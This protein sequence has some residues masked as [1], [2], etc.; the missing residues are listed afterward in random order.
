MKKLN[1]TFFGTP[2]FSVKILEKLKKEGFMPS[3]VVTTPDKP[4]GRK[5]VLT[6]PPTKIWAKENGINV[7][8]P[9]K[10]KDEEFLNKL[11]ETEWD[12]FI[13]ASYGKIIP[14]AVL[15]I[16]KH[17]TINVHPSLLPRL[18]GASPMQS[19]ILTEDK[20]GMTIMLM[21]AGM[22]HGPIL[23]QKELD[24]PN[25]PPKISE[26]ENMLAEI[27]GEML[28]ETIPLW[29]D[30]KITPQ[31]QNHD[32]ATYIDKI[33]K[34]EAVIDLN[35]NPE[36]NYR[37]IQALQNYKPHFFIKKNNTPNS[38]SKNGQ[39]KIRVIIKDAK[40]EAGEFIITRVLPEGKKEMDYQDFLRG[41]K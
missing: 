41:N 24:I 29:V 1:I 17:E 40:L 8:Q 11:K 33:E 18:R 5:L 6:S 9:T 21:D 3:L 27:G 26:L 13:V 34:E 16:P 39:R 28:T 19:A 15:D 32:E 38:T 14:Q 25:W 2:E 10:L 23:M 30:G 31:E 37:K 20:T 36:K 12:L 35:D 22:D 7:L 4:Q